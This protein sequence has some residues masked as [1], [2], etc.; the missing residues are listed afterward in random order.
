MNWYAIR[1][2]SGKESAIQESI[3]FEMDSFEEKNGK[4]TRYIKEVLAPSE[5]ITEM[6]DGKKRKRKKLFFPGYILLQ[7]EMTPE[8]QYFVENLNNV[9]NF[10][11][12]GGDPQSLSDKEV[13]KFLGVVNE[14]DKQETMSS[15]LRPGVEIKV[16]DGP[17]KDFEGIIKDV[18]EDRRKIK[19]MVTIFGRETSIELNDLQVEIER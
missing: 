4:N 17:F 18:N 14:K 6:R 13:Q 3:F 11:G 8:A 16:V 7:M 1:V 12:G 10:L 9:I 2:I 5:E 15:A 19:V